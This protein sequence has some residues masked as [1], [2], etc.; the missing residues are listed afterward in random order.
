M[1]YSHELFGRIESGS[2]IK[3]ILTKHFLYPSSGHFRRVSVHHTEYYSMLPNSSRLPD[4]LHWVFIIFESGDES[5]GI[6]GVIF[7]GH[8]VRIGQHKVAVK[9]VHPLTQHKG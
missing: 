8:V 2:D 1:N 6:E 9:Q 3:W 4:H 7:K 5:Q